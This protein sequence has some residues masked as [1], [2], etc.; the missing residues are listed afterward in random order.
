MIRVLMTGFEPFGGQKIN[1][2]WQAVLGV[3]APEGVELIK[4]E[5]PVRWFETGAAVEHHIGELAPDVILLTGQAG[6]AERIRVERVGLNLRDSGA[7]DNAG[8]IVRDAP[9]FDGAPTAYFSTFAYKE[10]LAA[11]TGAGLP[12]AYSF[13]AGAYL[14][15]EALYTA[16]HLMPKAKCGFIHLPYLPE[17]SDKHFTLPIDKQILALQ[18]VLNA[19]IAAMKD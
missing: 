5:L 1:P 15:N 12:A 13:S 16:L 17:Q 18:L 8:V 6:G 11:L 14:C 19:Q 9:V 4:R 2:S 7:K 3:T 10:I